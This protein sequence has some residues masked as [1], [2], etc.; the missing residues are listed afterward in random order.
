MLIMPSIKLNFNVSH[1]F[2]SIILIITYGC[3]S[4][5]S[6]SL[7]SADGIYSSKKNKE[8]ENSSNKYYENYFKDKALELEN[9]FVFSDS[10]NLNSDFVTSNDISYSS[11]QAAWGD[12]PDTIDYVVDYFPYRNRYFGY[13]F[14][15]SMNPYYGN[16][17]GGLS[18]FSMRSWYRYGWMYGYYP[19]YYDYYPYGWWGRTFPFNYRNRYSKYGSYNQ[20]IYN[21][22]L[23]RNSTENISYNQGKRG[24]SKGVVVYGN[25]NSTIS[26]RNSSNVS[27]VN[28]YNNGR[29]SA[30]QDDNTRGGKDTSFRSYKDFLRDN[31]STRNNI[32]RNRI[33][34]RPEMGVGV[35]TSGSRA[36]SSGNDVSRRY[37]TNPTNTSSGR[38]AKS[39][40]Y[41]WGLGGR[42]NFSGNSSSKGV[43]G[44]A[45]PRS[46]STPPRSYSSPSSANSSFSRPTSSSSINSSSSARG[47]SSVGSSGRGSR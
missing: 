28:N 10:I 15:G 11:N 47:S 29:S 12:I 14:Y 20:S 26:N 22:Y 19:F 41:N 44:Y 42:N 43:R 6:S 24:S 38:P 25:G 3:G 8:T 39:T 9:G 33:Y 30:I 1:L 7:V 45:N 31:N 17:Y 13:G 32:E 5:S 35:T 2:L 40:Q 46:S 21:N 16:W 18:Y 36:R 23:S 37:Y 34:S 4:F 27:S